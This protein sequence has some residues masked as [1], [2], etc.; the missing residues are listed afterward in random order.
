M[1]QA[2]PEA[3]SPSYRLEA[4]TPYMYTRLGDCVAQLTSRAREVLRRAFFLEE[5]AAET[6]EATG[7]SHTNVRVI[8]HSPSGMMACLA[9]EKAIRVVKFQEKAGGKVAATVAL[10]PP[11]PLWRRWLPDIGPRV[12]EEDDD[13]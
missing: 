2:D 11:K 6:A 8:R 12:E 1:L 13:E 9:E 5:L 7:L 4:A 3:G 10:A